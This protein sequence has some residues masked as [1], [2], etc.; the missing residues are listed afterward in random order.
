MRSASEIITQLAQ[1]RGRPPD[2]PFGIKALDRLFHQ[3][4]IGQ[5]GTGKSTLMLQMMRQDVENGQDFC[6]IDPHGDLSRS[7][8]AMCPEAI[9]WRPAD[10]NC[11]Y[12]YNP[13]TRVQNSYRYLVAAGLIDTLK[14]QWRDAWGARMEHLLRYALLALLERPDATLADIM[15]MFLDRSFRRTVIAGLSDEQV[16][17]FWTTEFPKMNYKTA[18][19]G[20]A[21][22]ANKL[23]AFLA[24]PAVRKSLCAPEKP[25]RFRKIMDEGQ[26]L[27]V[28]LAKGQLGADVANILGGMIVS[29]IALA[30]YSRQELAER[31][32][33][34]FFLY[35]DEFHSFTTA[36]FADMLSELR[37]YRLGLILAHQH[38]SQIDKDTFEAIL[39]NV[40]TLM[41]FRVGAT[42]AGILAKQFAA[43]LP[44]PRDLINLANYELF[45][46]LMIDGRTSKPF[47]GRAIWHHS[48]I[49]ILQSKNLV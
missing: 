47:S 35:I 11:P 18:A 34:P 1:T 33:R 43:D 7:L 13:L 44:Q 16:R 12:G 9:V 5:T 25:L 29:T 21:P 4:I 26:T 37:K 24:H 20:I 45:V 49:K 27:I 46:K 8:A 6:L 23:G 19:D 14:K 48:D 39:G 38:T 31:D 2:W 36:A 3:Y 42:D 10:L 41:A 30:A 40:G 32:R 28:D 22:I 17:E 15:P